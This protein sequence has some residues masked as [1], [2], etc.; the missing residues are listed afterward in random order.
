MISIES[1]KETLRVNYIKL[2]VTQTDSVEEFNEVYQ[3]WK[4]LEDKG[5]LNYGIPRTKS[6]GIKI[7]NIE[8]VIPAYE[9][10]SSQLG[11][12]L[13]VLA[14][15][16]N[17]EPA[18]YRLQYRSQIQEDTDGNQ[19]SGRTCFQIFTNELKK[20]NINIEDYYIDNGL[21]VKQTIE[22]AKIQLLDE[23]FKNLT[24]QN[25]H[26]LDIHNSYPSG[27]AEFIPEWRPAIERLYYGRKEHPE[28][29]LVLNATC[30]YFQ[31]PYRFKA[32]LAHVSKYAIHRNNEKIDK[33][34]EW[35]KQTGRV[36]V[37]LNT[38]GIWFVG[39]PTY[40]DN[41]ELGTFEEDHRNCTLRIK[42][43]GCYEYI[44]NG[45]YHPVVRGKTRLDH[46]KP[47]TEWQWGDI[48]NE[49]AKVIQ[50]VF[51]RKLGIMEI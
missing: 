22:K 23:G 9:V 30:G 13:L 37:L 40:L 29:K 45:E 17:G 38:D 28:Y 4:D 20:D 19:M 25:A 18:F 7:K 36:P 47:R 16:D 5:K 34:V 43:S 10:R 32:R 15:Y 11:A 27:M 44:E 46:I 31:T 39:E 1:A 12:E 2:P 3:Y 41:K 21:E 51:D 35:L 42:S 8:Q 48:Y 49:Q 14:H 26:H 24:L 50:L 6:G 33:M